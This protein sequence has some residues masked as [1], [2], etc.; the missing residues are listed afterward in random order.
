MCVCVCVC[1]GL[2]GGGVI[3][4][5]KTVGRPLEWISLNF[6]IHEG[7]ARLPHS[8]GSV[9][10]RRFFADFSATLFGFFFALLRVVREEFLVRF[11]HSSCILIFGRPTVFERF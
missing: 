11:P 6:A 1:V 5:I 4:K 3:E 2:G 10:A 7:S 8:D 9:R